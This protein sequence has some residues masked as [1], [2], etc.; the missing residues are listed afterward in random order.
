MQQLSC[1]LRFAERATGIAGSDAKYGLAKHRLAQVG[2]GRDRSFRDELSASEQ[3]IECS[4]GSSTTLSWPP[5]LTTE[6]VRFSSTSYAEGRFRATFDAQV[7]VTS[8]DGRFAASM[9]AMVVREPTP[10]EEDTLTIDITAQLG[11]LTA[12]ELASLLPEA[13]VE[14]SDFDSVFASSGAHHEFVEGSCR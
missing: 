4:D 7:E 9:P 14:S 3:T 6:T 13:D 1:R 8:E 5:S 11:E 12:E 10:G 2:A